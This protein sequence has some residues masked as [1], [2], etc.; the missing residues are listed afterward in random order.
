MHLGMSTIGV[1]ASLSKID[2]GNSSRFYSVWGVHDKRKEK[3]NIIP[4]A[5]MDSRR[6][7]VENE[8][9]SSPSRRP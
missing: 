6:I 3:K 1:E 7:Q 2:Q 9:S 8:P 4:L 5:M